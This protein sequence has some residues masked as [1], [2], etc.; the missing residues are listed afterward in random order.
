MKSKEK[1]IDILIS[2]WMC[3]GFMV[4]IGLISLI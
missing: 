4:V 2:V 3:V 1:A